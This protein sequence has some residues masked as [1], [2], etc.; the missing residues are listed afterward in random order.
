M[1]LGSIDHVKL[2]IVLNAHNELVRLV[3]DTSRHITVREVSFG[4]RHHKFKRT[5]YW[6][7]LQLAKEHAVISTEADL[8]FS[9]GHN[10]VKDSIDLER[11][12]L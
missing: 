5:F 4:Q 11:L 6:I 10:D 3:L 7:A 12:C 8:T 2:F 9:R 1:L